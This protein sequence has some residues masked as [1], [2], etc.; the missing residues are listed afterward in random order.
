MLELPTDRPRPQFQTFNGSVLSLDLPVEVSEKLEALSRREGATLFM[1]L[2]AAF[3]VLLSRYTGQTDISVGTPIADRNRAEMEGL[4]GFFIN[5][6]VLRVQMDGR[7]SY[8]EL[9]SRV[10]E[11]SLGA[12]GHQDVP[13]ERLVEELQPERDLS[14]TPLFQV[15]F[16][17]QNVP[18]EQMELEGLSLRS[19]ESDNRTAKF[20]LVLILQETDAGLQGSLTYNTDL[21]DASTIERMVRHFT[22]LLS[23]IAA[24]PDQPIAALPM[25]TEAERDRLLVEWNDTERP[26]PRESCIQSLFEEQV[27]R[28]PTAVAVA[29]GEQHL[30]YEELNRR[31]NQLAHYLQKQGVGPDVL[32]GICFERGIELIVGLLGILKAGGAYVPFDPNYPPQRLSFMLNDS[33]LAALLTQESLRERL[34][35]HQLQ[36]ICLD[37]DWKLIAQESDKDVISEVQPE[38]L[39]YVIYTSGSTGNPKGVYITHRGVIRLVVNTDYAELRSSDKIAQC[40]NA[41][42][43]AATFEIW[44]ALLHGAQL[45]VLDREVILSP[46]AFAAQLQESGITVLFVTTP[47]FN[48]FA[49]QTPRAFAN[50][51]Y[52]FFGADVVDPQWVRRVLENGAPK[53]LVHAYGPTEN[54]TYSSCYQVQEVRKG[55]NT[56]PIGRP[57]AN[58]QAYL[59]DKNLEPVPIGVAGELYLGGDGLARGYLGRPELTAEKFVPHPFA[60][61]GARLYRTGDLGRYLPDGNIEFLGRVDHQ[62]KLRGFRIELGEIESALN[63]HPELR[64]SVVV[65]SEDETDKRL[66]GYV[67]ATEDAAVTVAITAGGLRDYL[68]EHLPEYMVPAAFVFLEKLPLTANGKV[69]RRALP[70][71]ERADGGVEYVAPRTVVEEVLLGLWEDVLGAKQVG[72]HD[73]F[74]ELGG[75]SLLAM[76]LMSR[77]RQSFGVE[78]ALRAL[79]ESPSVA[80]IAQLL[81]SVE[82]TPGRIEKIAAAIKK[83]K[84]MSTEEKDEIREQM[85]RSKGQAS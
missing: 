71:P 36:R 38:N 55:A 68:K 28:T 85:K 54:A 45:I 83:V 43:D 64:E 60:Q 9:L 37:T 27:A 61:D 12:Y 40:S 21:F 63:S 29:H 16:A 65:L 19:E 17:L 24:N 13:F 44:G 56:V 77:V 81:V 14:H 20:N 49:D 22:I 72:V 52:V 58:S 46:P 84:S 80:Q 6:L 57:I 5:T 33:G 39:A 26:Y 66:I 11:V 15:A 41:A 47:L 42:F 82:E 18:H 74:F 3:D 79:F 67:V 73:N 2:L 10:R 59:L 53:H 75:H 35:E 31:A 78:L 1:R 50:L 7:E 23:A 8:R 48:H 30:S 51:R 34:P 70:A 32:V 4:I 69:D 25:L 62:V 76:Q